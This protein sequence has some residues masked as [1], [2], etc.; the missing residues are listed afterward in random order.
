MKKLMVVLLLFALTGIARNSSAVSSMPF[1]ELKPV[2]PETVCVIHIIHTPE[3][4]K[5]IIGEEATATF[6]FLA[7]V[8]KSDVLEKARNYI[9]H[10][11]N[12]EKVSS[13][14]L[15]CTFPKQQE[16]AQE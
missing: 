7:S 1:E 16:K 9:S 3:H 12:E 10:K 2:S 8:S 14:K 13:F 4:V 15:E 5:G 6:L 11:L